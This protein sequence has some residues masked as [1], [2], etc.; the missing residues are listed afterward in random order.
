MKLLLTQMLEKFPPFMETV[1]ITTATGP[2]SEP[3]EFS[4]SPQS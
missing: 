2:Y 3:V 4:P 1:F